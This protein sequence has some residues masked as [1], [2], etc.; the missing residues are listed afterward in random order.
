MEKLKKQIPW[1]TVIQILKCKKLLKLNNLK[2]VKR[3]V[4]NPMYKLT[5]I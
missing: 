1:Q 2:A 3:R 4:G 5:G